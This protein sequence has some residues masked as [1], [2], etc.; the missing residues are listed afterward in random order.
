MLNIKKINNHIAIHS[1]N[2]KKKIFNIFIYL[3]LIKKTNKNFYPISSE[4][5]FNDPEI[6]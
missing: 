2:F 1:L 6:L 3:E 5:V 4:A